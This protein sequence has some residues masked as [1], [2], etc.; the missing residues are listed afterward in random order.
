M[1][2]W[3]KEDFT[4]IE[5]KEFQNP[6]KK[7]RMK[8]IVHAWPKDAE[9]LMDAVK[10]FGYGGVATNPSQENGF[11][12]NQENLKDFDI[13]LKGLKEKELDYWI[14]DEKGYPSGYGGGLALEDHPELEAKGFYM[15]R[16]IAYAPRHAEFHLDEESDK[17]IWAAKYPV[18]CSVMNTSKIV[19]ESMEPVGF[20]ENHCACDLE[21]NEALFIFCVKSCYEGTHLVHNVCSRS[22]YINILDE[23]AV[24]RFLDVCYEPIAETSKTAYSN[25]QAVFTDEPSLMSAYMHGD[26][27]WPYAL[28]PW[29]EGLFE[30]FEDEYGF[31]LLPYL[32][33]IFEGR[34]SSWNIRVL[35]YQLIG[36]LVSKAYVTQISQWCH[37]HGTE[38]SGHYLAEEALRHHVLYY[39]SYLEVLKTTDYPGVDVLAAYPKI[40]HYNTTRFAQMAARK[41][42]SNGIM[43]ELCPFID[44]PYFEKEP[45]R[46]AAG[47]L[48]LLYL[49]GC[50]CINSYFSSNFSS[51]DPETLKKYRGYMTKEQAQWL[52]AYVGRL[53]YMLDGVQ[54]DCGTLIYYPLEDV[55]AKTRPGHCA[56]E[57]ADCD[58]D[59]SLLS[60]TKKI[61]EAG[62]DYLFADREDILEAIETLKEGPAKISG[63][64]VKCVIL[65]RMDA[66]WKDTWEALKKLKNAGVQILLADQLPYVQLGENIEFMLYDFREESIRGPKLTSTEE[67]QAM[68]EEEIL[69]VLSRQEQELSLWAEGNPML[70]KARFVK[71]R[72]EFYFVVNNSEADAEIYWEWKCHGEGKEI[73]SKAEVWN[74]S[75]GTVYIIE[76]GSSIS[77]AS[78]QGVFLVKG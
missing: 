48:N 56:Q 68:S 77:L 14:Y 9:V 47:I 38:F 67:F 10:E 2:N 35:F 19:Y 46:Y 31:S 39:G 3:I 17:I 49:G 23:K 16:R 57:S 36:K 43:T 4:M 8:T 5:K 13:L 60:L 37:E 32:P 74:P 40:Y 27:I 75:N 24:R 53:G 59:R 1:D 26:E 29:K 6:E 69:D 22:R 11:T 61:Y 73:E 55:Q 76:K 51:Y 25:A 54:N 71:E 44:I 21:K 34:E 18:D 63:I 50:R 15:V 12:S 30:D 33:Q 41:K 72:R 70:L 78:Y 45:V 42:G 20:T 7:Y 64:E 52:N 58:T 65:P 66:I 28:A 62:N